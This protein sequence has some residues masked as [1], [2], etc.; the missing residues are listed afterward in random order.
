MVESFIRVSHRLVLLTL[1]FKLNVVASKTAKEAIWL[2]KFLV[3]LQVIPSAGRL[4][5]LT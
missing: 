3:D 2:K 1:P 5:T 4:I